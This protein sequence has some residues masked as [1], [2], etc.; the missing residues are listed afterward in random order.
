MVGWG[1]T[2]NALM[3]ITIDYKYYKTKSSYGQ[4]S[5]KESRYKSELWSF[6]AR[7]SERSIYLTSRTRMKERVVVQLSRTALIARVRVGVPLCHQQFFN[8]FNQ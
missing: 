2:F 7:R 5:D 1:I 3:C 4:N 6:S 8:F